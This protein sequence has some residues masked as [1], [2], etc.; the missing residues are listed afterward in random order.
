[1]I[2]LEDKIEITMINTKDLENFRHHPY[3]VVDETLDE[4][5]ESIAKNGIIVPLVVRKKDNGKYEIISGHR[6]KRS[7]ELLGIEEVPCIVKELTDDEAIIEMVDSNIQREEVLPSE[8][9]WA[10][11]MKYDAMKRQGE[12]RDISLDFNEKPTCGHSVH[13]SRDFISEIQSGR[14]ATRYIRLTY[15]APKLLEMVDQKKIAL[16]PAV[17]ISYLRDSEQLILLYLIDEHEATPSISQAVQMKKLSREGKLTEEKMTE[18]L[19]EEKC[20]QKDKYKITY[21]DFEKVLPRNVVTPSEVEEYLLKCAAFC[22]ENRIN[23]NA[24]NIKEIKDKNIKS[25]ERGR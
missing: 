10:Y 15:L 16:K 17:E 20:N 3:K 8:K 4:M 7:S 6:R 23:L 13:K 24:V 22:I 25:K 1:V 14:N 2:L 9:A 18:I 12:R 5:K 11:K 19:S 21:Q